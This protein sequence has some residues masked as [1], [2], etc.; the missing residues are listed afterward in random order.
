MATASPVRYVAPYLAVRS[1]GSS[2]VFNT[3]DAIATYF[4]RVCVTAIV[5]S[6]R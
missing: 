3:A 5:T 6:Q 4:Q 2:E 1:D